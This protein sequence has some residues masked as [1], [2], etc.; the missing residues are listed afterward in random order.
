MNVFGIAKKTTIDY[1]HG[2]SETVYAIRPIF[3]DNKE[4]MPPMF[5]CLEMAN[6][7]IRIYNL[8]DCKV[9]ELDVD[10]STYHKF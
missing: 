7:F 2:D 4:I 9:I 8:Y 5:R 6:E 3:I 1:G 10:I